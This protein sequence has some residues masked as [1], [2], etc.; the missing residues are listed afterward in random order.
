M[1]SEYNVSHFS[2]HG[3]LHVKSKLE[4]RKP[5]SFL[6]SFSAR[7]TSLKL[8]KLC[9]NEPKVSGTWSFPAKMTTREKPNSRFL[10]GLKL[11][12]S[13]W[14]HGALGNDAPSASQTILR[15]ETVLQ[16]QRA[17]ECAAAPRD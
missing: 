15:S 17:M 2:I 3:S 5:G 6:L 14:I 12:F 13:A 8:V 4:L 9:Q 10:V 1:E 7:S 16:H 11:N